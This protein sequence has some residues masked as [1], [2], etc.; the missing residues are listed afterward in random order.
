MSEISSYSMGCTVLGGTFSSVLLIATEVGLFRVF[1]ECLDGSSF[2]YATF[3]LI[4]PCCS[5]VFD[6]FLSICTVL[7]NMD[8][9]SLPGT[10]LM[11][12]HVFNVVVTECV[13]GQTISLLVY[14]L[15]CVQFG[16][17]INEE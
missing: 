6:R 10:V 7:G 5:P 12:K 13:W 1:G 15:N 3:D 9:L 17:V 11:D 8:V 2:S 16:Y 14:K 4:P